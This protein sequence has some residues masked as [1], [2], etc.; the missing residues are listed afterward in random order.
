MTKPIRLFIIRHGQTYFNLFERFQGWS[1]IELTDK[2]IADA[3][4]AGN[5]LSNVHFDNAYSSD[6]S[7]AVDTAQYIL[8]EN[9]KDSPKHPALLKNFRE[10][11]FGSFDGLY[12]KNT[13]E[14]VSPESKSYGDLI[15]KIGTNKT[16]DLFNYKD[17]MHLAENSEMFWKRIYAGFEEIRENNPEGGNIL[18]VAHGSLIRTIGERF[19][20]HDYAIH[21][22]GNGAVSILDIDEYNNMEFEVFNDTTTKF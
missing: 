2:G 1:D 14:E 6:L 20:E 9:K 15:D 22:I 12:V 13:I 18:L 7:R 17:P 19:G 3:K 5:R 4:D 10:V 8:N 16:L 11:F 21:T